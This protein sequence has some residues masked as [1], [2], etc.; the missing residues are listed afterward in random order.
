MSPGKP[1]ILPPATATPGAAP[2]C[3]CA[4]AGSGRPAEAYVLVVLEKGDRG[5]K[6]AVTA[7][8]EIGDRAWVWSVLY[9]DL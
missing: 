1:R 5:V 7:A 6:D 8:R 9:K 3:V 2:G 4:S